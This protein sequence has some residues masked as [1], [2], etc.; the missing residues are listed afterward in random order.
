MAS[1]LATA[2]ARDMIEA[3][4]AGE[5]DPAAL[6]RLARGVMRKKI[7]EL[8]MAGDGRFTAAHAQMCRLHLDADDHLSGPGFMVRLPRRRPV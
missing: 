6:A 5:R 2:S 1:R 4:I 3:L 7:P 8:M